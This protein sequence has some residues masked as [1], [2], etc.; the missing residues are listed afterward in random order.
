MSELQLEADVSLEALM[1]ELANVQ[2][3]PSASKLSEPNVIE[4][5]QKL[6][7][8]GMLDVLFTTN[9]KEYLTPKQLR[10]E[11]EDEILAHGGRVN[12]TELPTLLNVD[13]PYIERVVDAL[14]REDV[15]LTLFQG[16]VIAEYYLDGIAE[17]IEQSLQSEGRR[18][19]P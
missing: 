17:E 11:V 10:H 18:A 2:K 14:L 4:V 8:L 16:D 15:T 9:G 19:S 7:E 5:V 13:L 6:S 3:A 1:A 12:V